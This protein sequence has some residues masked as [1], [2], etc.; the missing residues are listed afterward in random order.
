M[1]RM[2]AKFFCVFLVFDSMYVFA[3]VGNPVS[4]RQG[5]VLVAMSYRNYVCV[6]GGGAQCCGSLECLCVCIL[7]PGHHWGDS[8]TAVWLTLWDIQLWK[9]L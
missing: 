7:S 4:G 8:L 5:C 2:I 6:M 3:K 9:K 1:L